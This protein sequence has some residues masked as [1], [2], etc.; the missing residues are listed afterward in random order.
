MIGLFFTIIICIFNKSI[1][2]DLKKKE[3][4]RAEKRKK[5]G[6]YCGQ[7]IV[8]EDTPITYWNKHC[9]SNLKKPDYRQASALRTGNRNYVIQMICLI[10]ALLIVYRVEESTAG[11]RS[12]SII[13][14]DCLRVNILA[15]RTPAIQSS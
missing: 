13:T 9:E 15:Y 7:L 1:Y 2:G 11:F 4:R 8:R 6:C 14:P 5:S 10:N 3:L 12:A